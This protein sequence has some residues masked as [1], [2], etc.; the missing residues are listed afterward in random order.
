MWILLDTLSA[1]SV[2]NNSNLVTRIVRCEKDDNLTASTNGGYMTFRKKARLKILTL[3]VFFNE[4]SMATIISLKDVANMPGSR[5][6]MDTDVDRSISAI[7]K[8]RGELSS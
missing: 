2:S 7:S 3:D 6:I 4:N 1:H 5:I 8:E